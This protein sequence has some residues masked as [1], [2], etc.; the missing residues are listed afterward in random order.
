MAAEGGEGEGSSPSFYRWRFVFARKV[1]LLV[2]AV[3]FFTSV[4][5]R[6]VYL[7]KRRAAAVLDPNAEEGGVA[8]KTSGGSIRT[9]L[10]LTL[11]HFDRVKWTAL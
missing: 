7:E 5:H 9:G 3:F 4:S 1:E 11:Y 2:L 6:S 10:P 8:S